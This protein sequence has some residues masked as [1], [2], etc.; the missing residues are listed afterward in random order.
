MQ[1]PENIEAL[2]NELLTSFTE[3]RQ[4]PRRVIQAK[5]LANL[6]GKVLGTVKA[7]MVYALARGEEPDIPFLGPTSGKPLKAN[8]PELTP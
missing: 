4:D 7:Q 6:A 2:R 5:E 8:V 3:L 1:N